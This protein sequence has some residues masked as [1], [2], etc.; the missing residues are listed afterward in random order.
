MFLEKWGQI[1]FGRMRP[2]FFFTG[3]LLPLLGIALFLFF[4]FG[5]LYDLEERFARAARKEKLARE[6]KSR[7]DRF[8]QRYSHADPYFLD[9]QI[10]SFPLLQAEQQRLEKLLHH[11]AFLESQKLQERLAFLRE[12]RLAFT[13]ENIAT[14]PQMKEVE[15]KQRHPV[16]M[17]ENDLKKILSLIEDV[18]I[19]SILPATNSPQI[20]IKEFQLKKQK[21]V[22]QTEVFQIEMDLIKREFTKP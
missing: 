11:P 5:R 3:L 4:E 12:N 7:K 19:D 14:S 1:C 21:T 6:R 16:Q 17:D 10:E 8:F 20:L 22:L 18:S 13:E 9:R 15:E 2:L